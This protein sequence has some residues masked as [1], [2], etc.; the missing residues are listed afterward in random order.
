MH[1]SAPRLLLRP[2][3]GSADYPA[4]VEIWRGAVRA[5]HDFLDESDFNRI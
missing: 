2:G 5:T 3:R 4:V 1:A